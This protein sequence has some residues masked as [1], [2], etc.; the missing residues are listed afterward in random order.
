MS[1]G[2]WFAQLRLRLIAVPRRIW[3]AVLG[4]SLAAHVFALAVILALLFGGETGGG[5]EAD[6]IQ[7]MRPFD[8]NE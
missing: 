3:L 6:V 4:L 1:G 2:G 8:V 5:A 7:W